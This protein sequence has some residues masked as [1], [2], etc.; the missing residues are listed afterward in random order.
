MGSI[1]TDISKENRK[2]GAEVLF[3]Y[4][5]SQPSAVRYKNWKPITRCV[6]DTATGFF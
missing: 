5:G 2:I 4:T 3:Y 6:P 1:R